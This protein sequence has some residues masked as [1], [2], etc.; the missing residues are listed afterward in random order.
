MIFNLFEGGATEMHHAL[1]V[2]GGIMAHDGMDGARG[3]AAF[4]GGLNDS[5]YKALTLFGAQAG[6]GDDTRDADGAITVA[7]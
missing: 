1:I 4:H 2:G 3:A 6:R 7:A 5:G